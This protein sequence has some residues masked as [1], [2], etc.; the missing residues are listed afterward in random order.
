MSILLL[1]WR[2]NQFSVL[3]VHISEKVFKIFIK[4]YQKLFNRVAVDEMLVIKDFAEL[5]TNF[6]TFTMSKKVID[7]HGFIEKLLDKE[8]VLT[9]EKLKSL[10]N[11]Y[12]KE[13]QKE[14]EERNKR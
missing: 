1:S 2:L 11:D 8:F 3:F 12:E 13:V 5:V 10:R 14:L 6:K 9:D 4:K 7:C